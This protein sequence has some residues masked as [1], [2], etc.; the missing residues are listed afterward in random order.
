VSLR[1]FV[2]GLAP[3]LA[4]GAVMTAVLWFDGAGHLLPGTWL[5]LYGTAVLAAS[6]ATVRSVALMGALF[7]LLGLI[8]FVAPAGWANALLGAGFGGLHLGFG[9]HLT[10]V[11]SAGASRD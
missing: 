8:A 1:R 6:S 10:H 9:L 7:A 2:L 4:A 11:S 3:C 5:L